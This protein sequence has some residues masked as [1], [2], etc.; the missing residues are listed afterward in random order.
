MTS[1]REVL[2]TISASAPRRWLAVGC[3]WGLAF[4]LLYIALARP[5]ALGWQVF[6]LALGGG[7]LWVAERL[8][9]ATARVIELTETE[10]RDTSG[11]V[12]ARVADIDAVDRGVFA[13]KPSNGFLIR[14]RNAA[15]P[16]VWNPGLWW[17]IGRRIGVGGVTPGSQTKVVSDILQTMVAKRDGAA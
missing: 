13:F 4:L 7:A 6:L 5:P 10:L 17:R 12:I 1:D 16:G 15:G 14:T 3:L 11:A 2:A 9:R 8:R